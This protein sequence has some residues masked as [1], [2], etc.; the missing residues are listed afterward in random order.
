MLVVVC[1]NFCVV[2][3]VL[4]L[5]AVLARPTVSNQ[6]PSRP[7]FKKHRGLKETDTKSA[8][9]SRLISRLLSQII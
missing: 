7:G 2:F 8:I 5:R 6:L 3:C 4:W 1:L 9:F